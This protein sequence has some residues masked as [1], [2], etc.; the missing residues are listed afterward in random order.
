MR[1]DGETQRKE[2]KNKESDRVEKDWENKKGKQEEQETLTGIEEAVCGGEWYLFVVGSQKCLR[3][4]CPGKQ[5]N[6][7]TQQNGPKGK[8]E[9]FTWQ[10]EKSITAM[11]SGWRAVRGADYPSFGRE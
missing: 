7:Q 1:D 11:V 2:G 8:R 5:T 10:R 3:N 9:V 6:K 4:H